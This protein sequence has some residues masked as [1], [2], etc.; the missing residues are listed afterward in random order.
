[1]TVLYPLSESPIITGTASTCRKRPTYSIITHSFII[2]INGFK[3]VVESDSTSISMPKRFSAKGDNCHLPYDIKSPNRTDIIFNRFIFR[4]SARSYLLCALSRVIRTRPAILDLASDLFQGL[5]KK[6][7]QF[8][9]LFCGPAQ[10]ELRIQL[11]SDGRT[12]R[13]PATLSAYILLSTD[14]SHQFLCCD[15]GTATV[16]QFALVVWDH[17]PDFANCGFFQLGNIKS[18][19]EFKILPPDTAGS[20]Y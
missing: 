8:G 3:S 2:L 16:E 20:Y 18:P 4:I 15:R 13:R 5:L 6:G 9:N 14:L 12:S 7:R 17:C 11:E 19:S 1:M 10:L